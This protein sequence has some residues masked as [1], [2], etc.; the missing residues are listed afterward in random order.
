MMLNQSSKSSI[1]TYGP[2]SVL[3]RRIADCSDRRTQIGVCCSAWLSVCCLS[4]V[5]VVTSCGL[6]LGPTCRRVMDDRGCLPTSKT[7]QC[8]RSDI[9]VFVCV[10]LCRCL[11]LWLCLCVSVAVSVCICV[12][13]CVSVAFVGCVLVS[14]PV[15]CLPLCL[16]L[17][18]GLCVCMSVCLCLCVAVS[19]FVCLC[20]CV[21]VSIYVCGTDRH[22]DRDTHVDQQKNRQMHAQTLANHTA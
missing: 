8:G 11:Y 21:L 4:V 18:L 7:D 16:C 19:V 14:V 17:C 22:R 9:C 15:L 2:H 3:H 20:V 10:C 12:C 1:W 5:V 13:V 6:R